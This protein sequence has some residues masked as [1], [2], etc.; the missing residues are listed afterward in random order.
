MECNPKKLVLYFYQMK[1]FLVVLLALTFSLPI[2]GNVFAFSP[3][4]MDMDS[5]QGMGYSEMV[6]TL[7]EMPSTALQDES[8]S[9]DLTCN[10][11]N[12]TPSPGM[13]CCNSD[14]THSKIGM[15][16]WWASE[17]TIKSFSTTTYPVPTDA[18]Y[19]SLAVFCE[20]HPSTAPPP[21]RQS[22]S[23]LVGIIKRLD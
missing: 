16:E 15:W 11:Q 17:K 13:S 9:V 7:W 4:S 10:H 23:S 12:T 20:S 21:D 6:S 5:S 14:T 3:M 1:R 22:Y 18:D 19:K 8:V 2:C